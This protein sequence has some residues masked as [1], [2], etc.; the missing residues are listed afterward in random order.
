MSGSCRF[1][2]LPSHLITPLSMY[3]LNFLLEVLTLVL[4]S[5]DCSSVGNISLCM[6]EMHVVLAWSISCL[7]NI[8]S[9]AKILK[10]VSF[11]ILCNI[12]SILRLEVNFLPLKKFR[13][14][15]CLAIL[16]LS[17]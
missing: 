5:K 17:L 11:A 16:T 3:R 12:A 9:V 8:L 6:M 7:V 13:K 14:E 10:D 2:S 4:S 15:V 1:V